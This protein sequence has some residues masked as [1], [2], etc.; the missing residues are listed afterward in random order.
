MN[1]PPPQILDRRRLLLLAAGAVTLAILA[2]DLLSPLQGAVAV[3]YII[4]VLLV[5]QA[6]GRGAVIAAGTGCILLSLLA[7][8][9]GHLGA[10]VDS[11]VIRLGVSIVAIL[12]ATLLSIRDH[13]ARTT[14]AEQARILELGH[15]TVI[16]RDADDVILYWNEGAEQLYGWTR[17]EAVGQTCNDLLRSEF[18]AEQVSAALEAEGH[19]SGELIRTRRNGSRMV[20]ASRWLLRRDPNGRGIGVIE[21]SADLTE[22]MR[23]DAER[24]QSEQRY[25][26]I[27]NAAGFAIW[28]SDWS[29]TR[30]HLLEVMP[31]G[32]DARIWLEAN[33]QVVRT[34]VGKAIIGDVNQAALA[35]FG[36]SEKAAL[37]GRSVIADYTPET[38]PVFARILAALVEES[39]MVE[40]EVRYVT[41]SD[42][43][44]DT[45]LRVRVLPEGT[46]WSRVLMMALDVTER[47]EARAKLEQTSAELAHAV[48]ISTLGQLAASIAHEVN[49]PLTAI[50]NY[51]KS[52]IRWLG[53]E[54]PDMAEATMCLEHIVANGSRAAD[55]ISRVRSMARKGT[56]EAE[57][58][59]PVEV[60]QESMALVA[61][62]ARAS[63]VAMCLSSDHAITGIIGD[64][65]QVQQVLVNLLMNAVQSMRAVADR[66]R[67][68]QV[69]LEDAGE[70]L[71]RIAIMD[72]GTGIAGEPADI[73]APFFTTKADGMGMGLSIC[74][75]IVEAQGGRIEASNNREHGATIAFTLPTRVA[76]PSE[77][78]TRTQTSV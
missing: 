70:S 9:A 40:A 50:I 62:E 49:Q 53:R 20:L 24:R 28:E 51:G 58:L 59:D 29:E 69:R 52:G 31:A 34:C 73:F 30:R 44:I 46:P 10:P 35:M 33:P 65:V 72:S 21:S 2:A 11:A 61:R 56:P 1:Q 26:T 25:A 60:I 78:S 76:G 8:A 32:S 27:F 45:V 39:D 42:R 48:R 75:S 54:T 77:I 23:A 66:P 71:A 14:L 16:I 67:T 36:A 4:V 3:L 57:F 43:P 37:I 22:Q 63:N 6:G 15:D 17:S 18:P 5:A 12:A 38:E 74:R 19:W 47:N 41:A 13:S 55:V 7:F 68:L 64:R